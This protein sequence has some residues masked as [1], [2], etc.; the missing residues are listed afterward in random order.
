MA[1]SIQDVRGM[2]SQPQTAWQ[3]EIEIVGLSTGSE[4]GLTVRA[5]SASIPT[6][7]NEAFEINFK[8]RRT[9]FKGRDTS[10]H[11][12][13]ITFFDSEDWVAY[14]YFQEWHDALISNPVSGGGVTSALYKATVLV[15]T[16]STD[17]ETITSTTTL[18][19][20]FPTEIGEISLSYDTSENITFDVTMQFDQK[21]FE[22]A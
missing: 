9:F 10:P 15:K 20:A 3:Y 14:N 4:E 21:L 18:K 1:K 19:N 12:I 7:S 13:S 5:Q 11:T 17:G 6:T 2:A 8:D 22:A 16:F